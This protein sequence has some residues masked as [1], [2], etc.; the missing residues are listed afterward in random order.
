MSLHSSISDLINKRM[1]KVLL[2]A[3]SSLHPAQF[4][5]FRKMVL[6]EFG[7]N[8]LGKDLNQLANDN[9]PHGPGTDR[10]G[11]E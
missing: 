2:Y 1:S 9:G 5:A 10:Y 11:P 7:R 3:E 4:A 8:G 6:D